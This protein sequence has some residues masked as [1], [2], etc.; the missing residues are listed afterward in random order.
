MQYNVPYYVSKKKTQPF[1]SAL[2]ALVFSCILAQELK[3]IR[4]FLHLVTR[5]FLVVPCAWI[6]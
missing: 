4:L 5:Q 2:A 3:R 6:A 1:V